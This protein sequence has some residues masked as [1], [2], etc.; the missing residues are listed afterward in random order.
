VEDL[1]K[2]AAKVAKFRYQ[3]IKNEFWILMFMTQGQQRHGRD[4]RTAHFRVKIK[5]PPGRDYNVEIL[6][7]VFLG[8]EARVA[9][10]E[11]RAGLFP[12]SLNRP[13]TLVPGRPDVLKTSMFGGGTA[14]HQYPRVV[15]V[16]HLRRDHLFKHQYP[17]ESNRWYGHLQTETRRLGLPSALPSF[18]SAIKNRLAKSIKAQEDKPT[19]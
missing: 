6:T 4:E 1:V 16:S 8:P 9:N 17:H 18:S 11:W 10:Y 7:A 14:H 15:H 13:P 19:Y 5:E 2:D 3:L 12:Q